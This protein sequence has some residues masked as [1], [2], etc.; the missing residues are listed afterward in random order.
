L[1]TFNQI[2]WHTD[3]YYGFW[4]STAGDF[5]FPLASNMEWM[6][7]YSVRRRQSESIFHSNNNTAAVYQNFIKT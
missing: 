1:A 6:K 5:Y 2:S 4:M 3:K 7:I